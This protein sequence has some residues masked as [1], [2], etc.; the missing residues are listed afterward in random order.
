M[1]TNIFL[2]PNIM[3]SILMEELFTDIVSKEVPKLPFLLQPLFGQFV[4]IRTQAAVDC[5]HE[6]SGYTQDEEAANACGLS[7]GHRCHEGRGGG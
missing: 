3:F 4:L 2:Y 6:A 1:E 5:L 7:A